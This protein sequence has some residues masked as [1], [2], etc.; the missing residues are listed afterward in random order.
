MKEY[1]TLLN[2]HG[3]IENVV[4]H[5]NKKEV[6]RNHLRLKTSIAA[7][8]WL[9]SQS[10]AFRGHDETPQSRNKGNFLEL[11]LLLAEFNPDIAQVILG[12]SPYNSKY[13]SL[14]I[15]KEILGILA[16]QVRKQIRDEIGDSKFAILVDETCDVAKRE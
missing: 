14:G 1:Q 3:H 16:A 13:T 7:V 4:G 6:E 11:L 10:C 8:K 15:Q 2:Q 5:K 9:T 12:N